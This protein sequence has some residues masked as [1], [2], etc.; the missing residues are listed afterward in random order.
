[1]RM[2]M[3]VIEWIPFADLRE[4][5]T[6]S[7]DSVCI[8]KTD[9]PCSIRTMQGQA[10]LD[11]MWPMNRFFYQGNVELDPIALFILDLHFAIQIELVAQAASITT[12]RAAHTVKYIMN[13]YSSEKYVALCRVMRKPF[14]ISEACMAK[15]SGAVKGIACRRGRRLSARTMGAVPARC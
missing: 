11:A 8:V 2:T 1:M 13:R 9:D 4:V 7:L 5:R 14:Q 10:V 3:P 15:S 6:D 12:F